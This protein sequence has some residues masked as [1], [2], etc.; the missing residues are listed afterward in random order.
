MRP[1]PPASL[2]PAVLPSRAVDLKLVVG[3]GTEQ[4]IV[5]LVGDLTMSTACILGGVLTE[6]VDEGHR[7]LILD[8]SAL[9]SCDGAGW[10]LLL[11]I[12]WRLATV[13]GH[14]RII[15]LPPRLA[16][17]CTQMELAEVFGVGAA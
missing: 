6:L 15:G 2:P 7:F 3:S 13:S 5:T 9:D 12:R 1:L 11:G 10:N 8:A 16:R 14:L 17:L 4:T